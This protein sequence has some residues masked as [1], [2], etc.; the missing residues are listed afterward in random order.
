VTKTDIANAIW[1]R[2]FIHEYALQRAS[3]A[4]DDVGFRRRKENVAKAASESAHLARIAA[5][6]AI[7]TIET[8]EERVSMEQTP[9]TGDGS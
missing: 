1:L 3:P 2:V 9:K 7:A 5:K 8:N 6:A 4:A